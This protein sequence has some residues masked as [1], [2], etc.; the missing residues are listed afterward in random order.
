MISNRTRGRCSHPDPLPISL[1]SF[2]PI[3]FPTSPMTN[4]D[5][6][7]HSSFLAAQREG[8]CQLVRTCKG[9]RHAD[10]PCLLRAPLPPCA[11]GHTMLATFFR[12][13][14]RLG[15]FPWSSVDHRVTSLSCHQLTMS[16]SACHLNCFSNTTSYWLPC[17]SATNKCG[18]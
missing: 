9:L 15:P 4:S 1:H 14:F 3:L 5:K 6:D 11:A 17:S 16:S 7:A 2:D 18:D 8:V 13:E 10:S 12:C